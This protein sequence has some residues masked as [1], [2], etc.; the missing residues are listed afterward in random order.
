MS[1]ALINCNFPDDAKA[2]LAADGINAI[3]LPAWDE[4]DAPMSAHPDM[5]LFLGFGH[6]ICHRNY[7]DKNK[8]LID[9]IARESNLGLILSDEEIGKKYPRDAIFNACIVGDRLICNTNFVSKHIIELA[10]KN[11]AQI[12]HVNQGYTKCSTLVVSNN[13]IVTADRGIHKAAQRNG[14]N[15]LLIGAGNVSLEPYDYGF[16]G[17][18]TGLAEGKIYFCGG[19]DTHPDREKLLEFISLCGKK[20]VFL[21]FP[22]LCDTG[23]ILFIE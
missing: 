3:S 20:R 17:G 16:I 15:S 6:L 21:S 4:L 7:Y 1:T 13:D 5:L 2:M 11:N 19:L 18:A 12:I 14:I 23:S 22:E 10:N 8:S 9:S